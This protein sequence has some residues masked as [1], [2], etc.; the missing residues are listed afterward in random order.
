M[1][2]GFGLVTHNPL[3]RVALIALH[4]DFYGLVPCHLNVRR[5]VTIDL[6]KIDLK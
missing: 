4:Y 6:K 2:T 5:G 1:P 3:V